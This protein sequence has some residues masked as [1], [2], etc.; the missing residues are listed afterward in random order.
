MDVNLFPQLASVNQG[1]SIDRKVYRAMEKT[2]VAQR[3]TF[4]FSRPI[5]DDD[6]WV[7]VGLEYGV[8][9]AVQNMDYR[10]FPN[11]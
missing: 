3:G 10:I 11:P 8:F 2:C 7:P 4:Y 1:K 5:D 9:Q 6:T